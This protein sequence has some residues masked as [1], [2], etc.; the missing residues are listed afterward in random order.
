MN[1]PIPLIWII[2]LVCSIL[3]LSLI[4]PAVEQVRYQPSNAILDSNN[5]VQN[6][7]LNGDFEA[8]NVNFSSEYDYITDTIFHGHYTVTDNIHLL[9]FRLKSPPTGDHTSGK[10]NYLV[11]DSKIFRSSIKSKIWISNPVKVTKN[12]NYTF[13]A[14]V[15]NVGGGGSS[16]PE[17]TVS[18]NDKVIGKPFRIPHNSDKWEHL[19]YKWNSGHHHGKVV[20]AIE[21]NY[22]YQYIEDFAIDDIIFGKE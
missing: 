8:G 4:Q 10:G 13:S 19:Y 11:V 20:V 3:H 17:L 12:S 2:L 15:Y 21:N 5:Q 22:Y 16:S 9:N 14:W 7:I 1:P 18:I 6:L